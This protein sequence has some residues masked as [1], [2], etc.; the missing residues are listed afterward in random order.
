MK[1]LALTACLLGA[2]AAHAFA[3]GSDPRVIKHPKAYHPKAVHPTNPYLKH[4]NH[5]AAKPKKM[6]F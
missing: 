3:A 5:K 1:K 6:K 4:S 2:F